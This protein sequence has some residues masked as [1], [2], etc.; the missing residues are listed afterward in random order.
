M[1][2]IQQVL[3]ML[4]MDVIHDRIEHF[5]DIFVLVFGRYGGNVHV[6]L[7]GIHGDPAVKVDVTLMPVS[8]VK[9]ILHA[10]VESG[11]D[12][13]G[14][15][16]RYALNV[17]LSGKFLTHGKLIGECTCRGDADDYWKITHF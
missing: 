16:G 12:Y 15:V 4:P 10:A 11:N 5:S 1:A 14:S 7:S 8:R 13:S 3:I 2:L 6:S 9:F 17:F